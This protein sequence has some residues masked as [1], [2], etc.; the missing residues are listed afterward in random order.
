MVN[1]ITYLKKK[2]ILFA[3]TL[4]QQQQS[5]ARGFRPHII[6][7]S[8]EDIKLLSDSFILTLGIIGVSKKNFTKMKNIYFLFR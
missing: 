8:T 1:K 4:Q 7:C 3:L 6:V 5:L 2:I